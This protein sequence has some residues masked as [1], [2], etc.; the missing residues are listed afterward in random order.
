MSSV[1]C[2]DFDGT[3]VHSNHLWSNSLWKAITTAAPELRITLKDIQKYT[4]SGFSWHRPALAYTN[5]TGEKWWQDML[6]RFRDIYL[7]LGADTET[8]NKAAAQICPII[9][10]SDNY[11]L[12]PDAVDSLQHIQD[13]GHINV[14]LSNNY[15][16]LPDVIEQ[17]GLS[18]YFDT[19]FISAQIGYEKPRAELFSMVK[20]KYPNAESFFMIGDSINADIIGGKNSGM[21]TVLVHRGFH[22]DADYCYEQ[23]ISLCQIPG[24]GRTFGTKEKKLNYT[25]RTGA[26]LIC[27]KKGKMAVIQTPKGYFLPGGGLEQNE[28]HKD[29]IVRELLEETGC[30]CQI[31]H[32][33]CCA[34]TY[35]VH[36][37][38]GPFHPIQYYYSGNLKK[39]ISEPTETEHTLTWMPLHEAA[40]KLFLPMQRWATE[41]YSKIPPKQ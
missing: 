35:T 10:S 3:L 12:Y 33:V 22:P 21:K 29:C 14:L 30:S 23:L 4:R 8:A 32:L 2:W 39:K 20:K 5:R 34:D 37:K 17:L 41:Q 19:L 38:I 26:Y 40:Q 31:N 9:K 18:Q 1:F 36:E 27:V 13:I 6:A 28:T 15:P 24:T 25:D 7:Q 16:D 11:S